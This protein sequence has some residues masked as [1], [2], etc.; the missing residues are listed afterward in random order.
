MLRERGKEQELQQVC[1]EM[2]SELTDLKQAFTDLMMAVLETI[3][4]TRQIRW[5]GLILEL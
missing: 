4:V 2:K 3:K 5:G 1:V